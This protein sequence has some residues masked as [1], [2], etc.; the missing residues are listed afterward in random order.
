MTRLLSLRNI[1]TSPTNKLKQ[2][3]WESVPLGPPDAILGITEAFRADK[4]PKKVN[5]GVGAYRDNDVNFCLVFVE[6]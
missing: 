2:S 1:M 6:Y 5:L 4:H 3:I